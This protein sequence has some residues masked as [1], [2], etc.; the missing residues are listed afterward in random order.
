[1][2]RENVSTEGEEDEDDVMDDVMTRIERG[3]SYH[4]HH[5]IVGLPV[6]GGRHGRRRM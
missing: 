5:K 6:V 2:C 4:L 1:M 3:Q